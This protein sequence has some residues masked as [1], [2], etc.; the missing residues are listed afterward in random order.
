MCE[1][2]FQAQRTTQ[3]PMYIG[4]GRLCKLGDSTHFPDTN[5]R[6]DQFSLRSNLWY[7]F[8]WTSLGRLED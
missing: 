1:S 5:F 2:R 7:T 8:D 3:Y 6:G 4:T